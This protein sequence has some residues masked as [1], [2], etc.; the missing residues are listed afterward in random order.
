MSI[1]RSSD[2]PT[3]V[4]SY[5]LWA[6]FAV[7]FLVLEMFGLA[8][9][10]PLK[11]KVPWFTLSE[12]VWALERWWWPLRGVMLVVGIDVLVHLLFGTPLAPL[13]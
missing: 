9:R 11:G 3:R 5:A 7:L 6:G 10:G 8:R 4:W 13:P 2:R 1:R 12:A